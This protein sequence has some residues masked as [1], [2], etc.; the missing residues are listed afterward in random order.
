[1]EH[2]ADNREV[3]SSNLFGPIN[4]FISCGNNI[5]KSRISFDFFWQIEDLFRAPGP[6]CLPQGTISSRRGFAVSD[7]PIRTSSGQSS[8]FDLALTIPSAGWL[9]GETALSVGTELHLLHWKSRAVVSPSHQDSARQGHSPDASVT[10]GDRP[11]R[12]GILR[13][14]TE[15]PPKAHKESPPRGTTTCRPT[16]S[17]PARVST[18]FGR[19]TRHLE[20]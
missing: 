4:P 13:R 18:F 12:D 5:E 6:L 16:T 11:S 9:V 10:I 17:P 15:D 8:W 14:Q 20:T 3:K 19:P 1:V 7:G 2:P